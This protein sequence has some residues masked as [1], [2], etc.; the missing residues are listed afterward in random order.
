MSIT[1]SINIYVNHMICQHLCQ[2]YDLSTFMSITWSVNIYVNHMIS[3]LLCQSYVLSTFMSITW[4]LNIYVSHMI[5]QLL[6]SVTWSV[7]YL[8]QSHDLSTTFI[9]WLWIFLILIGLEGSLLPLTELHVHHAI[10]HVRLI[11]LMSQLVRT[12]I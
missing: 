10:L 1:W 6:M 11:N 9:K 5:S 7:N 8:C 4:S 12:Q 2:S 3:Q